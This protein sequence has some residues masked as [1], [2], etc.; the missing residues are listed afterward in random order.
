MNRSGRTKY[1]SEIRFCDACIQRNAS[2]PAIDGKPA[3][4]VH[5][6]PR[7][8]SG[9]GEMVVWYWHIPYQAA[10]QHPLPS[11]GVF[12]T[13]IHSGLHGSKVG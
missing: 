5:N 8:C 9:C 3:K 11:D 10:A 12:F 6:S 2:G 13:Q 1:V 4:R 7:K